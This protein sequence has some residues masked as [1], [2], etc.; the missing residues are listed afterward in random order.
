MD[1]EN[2]RNRLSTSSSSSNESISDE[3]ENLNG[4]DEG[5]RARLVEKILQQRIKKEDQAEADYII[6]R[7]VEA[8]RL[9]EREARYAEEARKFNES[10]P[11]SYWIWGFE[12]AERAA[13]R[14]QILEN[15]EEHLRQ[16]LEAAFYGKS[17]ADRRIQKRAKETVEE[18]AQRR[19]KF[20]EDYVDNHLKWIQERKERRIERNRASFERLPKC[21]PPKRRR[22]F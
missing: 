17:E 8:E 16:H 18:K 3:D 9:A 1:M 22:S 20:A 5:N 4:D 21:N 15:A 12:T 14:K 6:R 11:L 7:R 10:I 2:H 13:R 19:L